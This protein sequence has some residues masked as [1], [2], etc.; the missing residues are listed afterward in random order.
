MGQTWEEPVFFR[1]IKE[2]LTLAEEFPLRN[3]HLQ[4]TAL[5]EHNT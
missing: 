5:T 2:S 4:Q 1:V 3:G